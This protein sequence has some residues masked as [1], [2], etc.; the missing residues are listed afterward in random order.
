MTNKSSKYVVYMLRRLPQGIFGE[1]YAIATGTEIAPGEYRAEH[2]ILTQR[3]SEALH[4]GNSA[5]FGGNI[6]PELGVIDID[7]VIAEAY[8]QAEIDLLLLLEKRAMELERPDLAYLPFELEPRSGALMSCWMRGRFTTQ[9][10]ALKDSTKCST[11][12]FYLGLLQQ[13]SVTGPAR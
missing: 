10:T 1:T 13:N 12:A 8:R 11:L 2:F 6:P 4:V 9:I 7:F 5:I 3:P